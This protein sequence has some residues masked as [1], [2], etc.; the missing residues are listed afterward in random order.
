MNANTWDFLEYLV[1]CASYTTRVIYSFLLFFSS[2]YKINRH[3]EFESLNNIYYV[4]QIIQAEYIKIG[5]NNI[6]AALSSK[7]LWMH[8]IYIRTRLKFWI[9]FCT[10]LA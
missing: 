8:A 4:H 1:T 6:S 5:K 3:A 2:H 7:D 9:K 10:I